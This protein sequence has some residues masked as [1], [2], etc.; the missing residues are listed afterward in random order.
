VVVGVG[1]DVVVAGAGVVLAEVDEAEEAE[2][3]EFPVGEGPGLG[4]VGRPG[5]LGLGAAVVG[6]AYGEVEDF[7]DAED[8]PGLFAGSALA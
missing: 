1:V 4:V 2:V 6:V 5:E 7:V 3:L 8:A